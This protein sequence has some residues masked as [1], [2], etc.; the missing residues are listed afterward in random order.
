VKLFVTACC[1]TAC[2][3]GVAARAQDLAPPAQTAA[4]A[5]QDAAPTPPA[6]DAAAAPPEQTRPSFTV[7]LLGI[8]SEALARGIRPEIVEAALGNID[9]PMP[10]IIERDRAQAEVVLPLERYINRRLTATLIKIGREKYGEQKAIL[11]EVA[12]K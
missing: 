1:I 11:E 7:W 4:P 2:A 3:L 9:E 6:T 10:V 5:T 12:K 8:R